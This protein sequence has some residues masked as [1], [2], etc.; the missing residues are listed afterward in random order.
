MSFISHSKSKAADNSRYCK[1]RETF[2]SALVK[3]VDAH[4]FDGITLM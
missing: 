4:R 3:Q 2:G 1:V